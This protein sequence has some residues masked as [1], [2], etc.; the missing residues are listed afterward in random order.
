MEYKE[1]R[2]IL[3]RNIRSRETFPE[4]DDVDMPGMH[5]DL[6]ALLRKFN[7]GRWTPAAVLV[8][9][10]DRGESLNVL[11]TQRAEGLKHHPGQISF[12]GGRI[13]AQDEGP[14]AAALR[15]AHE[16]IN[17]EPG[18]V[19]VLGHLPA[20]LTISHYRVTPVIGLVRPGFTLVPD[21]VEA[22]DAFE[23]PLAF[24]MDVANHTL[25]QRQIFDRLV[26]VYE[27]HY[28]G[29]NIWGA[30]AGMIVSLHQQLFVGK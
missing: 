28:Q 30:T 12:P 11:L 20:Y 18:F 26:P 5:G 7:P 27:I 6:P 21:M 24:L 25:R 29:R 9:I 4:L 19:D 22:T 13:E 1:L 14:D 17:L 2:D 3:H 10:V 15:E 8:P 23:V 16:E